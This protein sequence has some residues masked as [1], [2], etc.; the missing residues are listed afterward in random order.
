MQTVWSGHGEATALGQRGAIGATAI[1]KVFLEDGQFAAFD[2]QAVEGYRV[3]EVG[4]IQHQVG[5][6]RVAI[7]ILQGVGEGLDA[8]TTTVQVDEV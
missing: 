7:G 3:I 8:G 6:R 2:I 5:G 4:D 1:D